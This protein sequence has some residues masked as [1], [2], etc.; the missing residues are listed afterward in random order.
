MKITII[1]HNYFPED[2]GIGLY[3]TGMAEFLASKHDVTILTGVPYY[4]QWK[5]H[6]NYID[7]TLFSKETINRVTVHRFKQY[8]PAKPNFFNRVLQMVH[9]F[10]GT[11]FTGLKSDKADLIIVVMPF[12]ISILAGWFIKHTKGGKLWVHIQ[13]FEFDAA[14]KAGASTK[15]SLASEIFFKIEKWT[16]LRADFSSTISKA[17]MLKL[18][19]KRKGNQ[20]YFPNWIDYSLIN[21]ETAQ[22]N[23]LFNPNTFNILYSGNI[24]EK[25]DWNF[26]IDFVTAMQVH[27]EFHFYLVG[28]GAKREVV[29][30]QLNRKI[31]FSYYP[32]VAYKELNNLLCGAD[33][34]V[35]F[36][37]PEF[38]DLVMPSKILGMM[39]SAKPSIVTGHEDSE[40]K[41]NFENSQGG[42]YF[43]ENTIEVIKR[44][45]LYLKNNPENSNEVG[46]AARNFVIEHFSRE[47]VLS[48]FQL[49]IEQSV[50][51]K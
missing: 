48:E 44:C 19:Q 25:Q 30:A 51:N 47:K 29:V 15:N 24:G 28:E 9:F 20:V 31:N 49:K 23:I 22:A 17:M 39:A 26:Y 46:I 37:K 35:L 36:Q 38:K 1:S 3:S 14:F 7:N 12:T 45:I 42:Y 18:A 13:D 21:P 27:P 40:I 8:T 41:I 6:S 10:L 5:I 32:P 11:L 33:V 2:S 34:H 4:P 43:H 50:Q 16:L